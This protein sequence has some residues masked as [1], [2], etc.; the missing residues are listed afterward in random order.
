MF[1]NI[2]CLTFKKNH[3]V[4]TLNVNALGTPVGLERA[5]ANVYYYYYYYTANRTHALYIYIYMRT[6]C[7]F[8]IAVCVWCWCT[9]Q[10][11]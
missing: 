1:W 9:K 3:A 8:T 4:Y 11:Q 10:V 2:E 7:V 5:L 6:Q